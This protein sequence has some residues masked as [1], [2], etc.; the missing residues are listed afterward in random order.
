MS[1]TNEV[2]VC[3]GCGGATTLAGH[4]CTQ[5]MPKP[6]PIKTFRDELAMAALC[7][8]VYLATNISMKNSFPCRP[9][10]LAVECYR[11]ADAMLKIKEEGL[12]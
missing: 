8:A 9:K 6:E 10:D 12:P 5:W 11:V 7:G 1:D 4:I 2:P 3:P